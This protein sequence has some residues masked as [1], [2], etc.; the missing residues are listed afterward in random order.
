MVRRFSTESGLKSAPIT[1]VM[2]RPINIGLGFYERERF[3]I[4]SRSFR[5]G[6]SNYH[7]ATSPASTPVSDRRSGRVSETEFFQYGFAQTLR[8]RG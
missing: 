2:A 4:D 3:H 1:P 8:F 7:T 6:G 5:R